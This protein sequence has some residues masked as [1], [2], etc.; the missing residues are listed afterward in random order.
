MAPGDPVP[1]TV[2]S[3]SVWRPANF[4]EPS[5]WTV[6]LSAAERG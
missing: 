6:T 5:E 2:S 3:P 4:A 1:G